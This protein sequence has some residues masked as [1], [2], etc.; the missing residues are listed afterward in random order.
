MEKTDTTTILKVVMKL[1]GPITPVGE[2]TQ[3]DE[4]FENLK[5]M[6]DLVEKLIM[7]I[8]YVAH[9]NKDAYEFSKNRAGEYAQ[10]FITSLTP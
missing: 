3:D 1:M 7:G 5:S 6:C 9:S 2:T 4:R 8:E 10:K